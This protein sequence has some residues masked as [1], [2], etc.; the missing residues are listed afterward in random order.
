MY[1]DD[2]RSEYKFPNQTLTQ[3]RQNIT[4]ENVSMKRCHNIELKHV[5]I[6]YSM[7]ILGWDAVVKAWLMCFHVALI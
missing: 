4:D 6:T 7:N 3:K 5:E 2:E 1:I